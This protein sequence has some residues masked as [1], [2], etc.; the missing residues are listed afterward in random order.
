MTSRLELQEKVAI[1][2][3]SICFYF[4]EWTG[5]HRHCGSNVI[6]AVY[7]CSELDKIVSPGQIYVSWE[8]ASCGD[9]VELQVPF[10][11]AQGK[12]FDFASR[13]DAARG[14]AQDDNFYWFLA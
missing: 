10:D 8:A 3:A 12:L 9:G 11:F 6:C 4:N 14:F 2:C 1:L 7:A 13:G 5:T